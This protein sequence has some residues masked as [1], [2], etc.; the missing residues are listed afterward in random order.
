MKKTNKKTNV[1]FIVKLVAIVFSLVTVTF[2]WFVFS[3]DGWINPFDINV[4]KV[5]NVTI[6]DDGEHWTSDLVINEDSNN[7]AT[8][9]EFSGNGE[10][11]YIPV[12][13]NKQITKYYKPDYSSRENK[14]F[15]DFDFEVKTDGPIKF[16]LDPSSSIAPSSDE[17]K[18]N[19][20][21]AVRV[22]FLVNNRVPVIWAP[23]STYQYVD[24]ETFNKNGT[25]E[26]SYSFVYKDGNDEFVEKDS[27]VTINTNSSESG[28]SSLS[29]N[30][31]VDF[32]WGDLNKISNYTGTVE[33]IF[34][35]SSSVNGELIVPITIRVWVEGTDREAVAPLV[36]GKVKMNLKFMTTEV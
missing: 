28:Y 9:T 24:T 20:A 23:N 12:I 21:G 17:Y 1:S 7:Y 25:V 5:V 2:S 11:L 22:A 4:T 6:S 32:M 34:K 26:E 30:G 31:C 35:T 19:I 14:E 10:K 18:D 16:F 13:N 33:P 3:K 27:I 29:S 36:G 8:F 15:I